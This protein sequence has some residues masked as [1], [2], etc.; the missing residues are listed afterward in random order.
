MEMEIINVALNVD[1]GV[2][3]I[4][5]TASRESKDVEIKLQSEETVDTITLQ[6]N[7]YKSTINIAHQFD[8]SCLAIC[9]GKALIGPILECWWKN[10]K[11][12][13]DFMDCLK[14]KSIELAASAIECATECL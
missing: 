3:A 7:D 1:A 2:N 10:N 14:G 8:A 6:F 12:W 4:T 11:N 5:I 13:N 9:V